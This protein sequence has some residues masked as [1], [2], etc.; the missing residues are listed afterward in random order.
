M[1]RQFQR[2]IEKLEQLR[3]MGTPEPAWWTQSG[4]AWA[5]PV[6]FSRD[7][8]GHDHWDVQADILRSVANNAR[9][10]VKAC[11][12][13]GKTFC[14]ADVVLWWIAAHHNGIAITTAPT[15]TQVEKVLWGEIRKSVGG[16]AIRYPKPCKTRLEL[17]PNRYALGLST[18]EGV[19]FQGFHGKILI[20]IDEAPGVR[21]DIYDAI[22]GI[23]AGGDVHVLALGNPVLASGPFYDA[24]TVNRDG[25]SLFTIGAFDTPNLEGLDLESLLALPEGQLDRNVRPYLTT[26]RWVK[27]KYKEWGPGHSLWESRVMGCFPKQSQDALISLAWLEAAQKREPAPA[28]TS[29]PLVAG[30]DVAGPGDAET[31]VVV[32]RGNDVVDMRSITADD[33]RGEVLAVL[34]PYQAQL[35]WVTVDGIGI[36]W[37]MF[38]HLGEYFN[39]QGV[40]VSQ[41]AF[42]RERF[43]NLK[44]ELY[45]GLRMR[46]ESGAVAALTDAKTIAQLASLRYRHNARGQ[47]VIESKDEARKRGVKSPDR[48]EA[49]MLAF[50][51]NMVPCD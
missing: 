45:W 1:L 31:V 36:G 44:A 4:S 7:I 47:V 12:S 46:F 40:N 18:N 39:V 13:S 22:E 25:W 19:R 16:A 21:P 35:Q 23:R 38:Q 11:H 43:S 9:T 42:D 30:V 50:A 20:V 41:A 48:G 26:R 6:E 37:Y 34:L 14:A 15:W 28:S 10:A 33:A 24:F 2:R 3:D 5:D 32:R 27:E 51:P 17:G 8:L 49:M 29:E